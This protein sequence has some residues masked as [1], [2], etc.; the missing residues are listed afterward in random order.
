MKLELSVLAYHLNDEYRQ[1]T[2]EYQA[3]E[4]TLLTRVR[5]YD[6]NQDTDDTVYLVGAQELIKCVAPPKNVICIGTILQAG[7]FFGEKKINALVFPEDTDTRLLYQSVCEI[8]FKYNDYEREIKDALINEE[9]ISAA[10]NIVSEMFGNPVFVTDA[11]LRFI[12]KSISCENVMDIQL[13]DSIRSGF[14]SQDVINA[15][16]E[17]GLINVL[18]KSKKAIYIDQK[19]IM[20]FF[21]AN[22][23]END[24]RIASI[25]V[26]GYE[27]ALDVR[28]LPILNQTVEILKTA[29]YRLG[30][31]YYLQ[32]T[33]LQKIILDMLGGVLLDPKVLRSTLKTIHWGLND[34]YQ[35]IRVEI[36]PQK[37]SVGTAKYMEQ[38]VKGLFPDSILVDFEDTFLLVIHRTGHDNLDEIIGGELKLF[39]KAQNSKVGISMLYYDFS[40]SGEAYK[41]AGIAIEKGQIVPR[42]QILYHYEDYIIEHIIDMCALSVDII[43]LCHPEAIR[44]YQY[45]MKNN[46]SYL[47]SLYMSA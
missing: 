42:N 30:S 8:F 23:L 41:L 6:G 26:S 20:P 45:D 16:H 13:Q 2:E 18:N 12:G 3:N 31:A 46:T 40:L 10:L 28:M 25:T 15:L 38:Y 36:D 1:I 47:K 29:V 35:L 7:N 5:F 43:S 21:C 34:E 17:A 4:R 9:S 39:L 11:A 27:N 14:S 33:N 32:S 22:F 37:V 44:L 24:K 19:P